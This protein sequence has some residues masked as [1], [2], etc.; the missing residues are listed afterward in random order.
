MHSCQAVVLDDHIL[1]VLEN[2]PA[3]QRK[4]KKEKG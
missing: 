4:H 1:M 2:V 3:F